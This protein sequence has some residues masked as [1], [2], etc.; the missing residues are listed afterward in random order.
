MIRRDAETPAG[1]PRTRSL[2]LGALLALLMTGPA[3]VPDVPR[4][5]GDVAPDTLEPPEDDAAD[6]L[7]GPD[8]V[9]PAADVDI[10]EP[11]AC[12]RDSDCAFV[13]GCCIYGACSAGTCV[14]RATNDCCAVLGPCAVTTLLHTAECVETCVAGGCEQRL[15]L[16]DGACGEVWRLAVAAPDVLASLAI[17][18]AAEDRVTWHASSRRPFDGHASLHAGDVLCPTYHTG[19]LGP[20]CAPR[21]PELPANPVKLTL[22]TPPVALPGEAPSVARVWLW[23][24]LEEPSARAGA[25]DGLEIALIG[26]NGRLVTAWSSRNGEPPPRRAWFPV[27]LDLSAF[28]A[29]EARLRL[30]FDTYDGNDNDHEGVYVGAIEIETPCAGAREC[31]ADG[32]CAVG[33]ETPVAGTADALCVVAPP[34]VTEPCVTCSGDGACDAL[35]PCGHCGAGGV[36]ALDPSCCD[37]AEALVD[38]PSFET[39]AL[40]A[41]WSATEAPPPDAPGWHVSP[42][43]AASG[44]ASLR[45]GDPLVARLAPPGE[46]AAGEVTTPILRVPADAPTLAFSLW[47]STEFDGDPDPDNPAGVDLL[48]VVIGVEAPP[49]V[50][51]P[52]VVVWDSRQVGGTTDGAWARVAIPLPGY[53]GDDVRVTWRFST[54]DAQR[55]EGEGVYV[56]DV[57]LAAGC[58]EGGGDPETGPVI[59]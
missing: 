40:P 31:P 57:S 23:M 35:G 51:L 45:F 52:S 29:D 14:A 17:T 7:T 18:D 55:N 50:T 11:T 1:R 8:D 28:A 54:G 27:L 39:G 4:D 25:F 9:A 22:T 12:V 46:A 49:G 19:P 33:R 3:C 13:A 2:A 42:W 30:T 10:G 24:D 36:C 37:P 44:L 53:A 5:A 34:D 41:G 6:A 26:G 58:A 48:E 15:A 20:D 21:T 47:L 43:R 38:D 32:P 16:S 56:D 59:P